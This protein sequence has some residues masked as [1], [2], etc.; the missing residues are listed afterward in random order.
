MANE[1][2]SKESILDYVD[3]LA[4]VELDYRIPDG[5]LAVYADTTVIQHT[6]NEFTISFFQV[7]R[8]IRLK[9]ENPKK[10]IPIKAQCVSRIVFS[11]EQMAKFIQALQTNMNRYQKLIDELIEREKKS[12]ER[13]EEQ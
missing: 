12:A 3:I 6:P 13:K 11:P 4:P 10:L 1:K 9:P 5:M 2:N 8:P 7:E